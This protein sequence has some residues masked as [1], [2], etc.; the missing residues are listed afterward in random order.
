MA[1]KEEERV[2]G[3]GSGWEVGLLSELDDSFDNIEMEVWCNCLVVWAASI[4]VGGAGC[5]RLST[6]RN[7]GG[8]GSR[9]ATKMK[10]DFD[11]D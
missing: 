4:H 5:C 3:C 8:S 2:V 6:I 9:M 11:S 10:G 7:F 1:L